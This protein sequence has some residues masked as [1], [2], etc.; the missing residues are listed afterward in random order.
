MRDRPEDVLPGREGK[1]DSLAAQTGDRLVA[2]DPEATG[3]HEDKVRLHLLELDGKPCRREGLSQEAGA[4][5]VLGEA[6]DVVLERIEAGGRDD[7]RLAHGT[8]EEVLHATRF[9]HPLARAGH[10]RAER[11]AETLGEAKRHR[12]ELAS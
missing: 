5:M 12:V 1:K 3:V 7:A 2:G 4:R 11:A 6:V 10:E 9:R 8:A